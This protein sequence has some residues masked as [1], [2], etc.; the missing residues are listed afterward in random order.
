MISQDFFVANPDVEPKSETD[1]HLSLTSGENVNP[2][3]DS[4]KLM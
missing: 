1:C 3:S 2:D 4:C